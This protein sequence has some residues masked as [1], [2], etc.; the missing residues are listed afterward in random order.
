MALPSHCES[1]LMNKKEI[2]FISS[3][4]IEE[5]LTMQDS[6]EA[7]KSAFINLSAGKA[8]VPQRTSLKL[9]KGKGE[10]LFMPAYEKDSEYVSLKIV[11]VFK[12][13]PKL[14]LPKI[15]ALIFLMNAENGTPV[16]VM[17][18]ELITAMRTGAVTGLATDLLSRKNSKTA[19]IFGTS[20][21]A[22]R[23]LEAIDCVRKL[24]KVFV[25]GTSIEKA[26]KFIDENEG[27]YS[28]NL[29]TEEDKSFIKECDIICTATSS[30]TPVFNDANLKEGVHINSIGSYKPEMNEIPEETIARSKVV[31]DSISACLKE[32]G[33][34]IKPI[35]SGLIIR[36]H[37]YAE[38]GEIASGLKPGRK[39]DKEITVFK[40]VGI[41]IQDLVVASIILKKAKLL[42]KGLSVN[43]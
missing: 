25:F 27:K 35:N 5:L 8:D 22:K 43:L 26:Q 6:I 10:A 3:A 37:I 36:E 19:A 17:D 30:Y 13:N 18:G 40:S 32:A 20:V 1:R 15:Q 12:D 24:E 7:M 31:V 39:N 21:Q 23:Q 2:L 9:F 33:D 16:A 14:N 42:N 4:E 38:L 34:I 29:I 41:A 11:S 28:F